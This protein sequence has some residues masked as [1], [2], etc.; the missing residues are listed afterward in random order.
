MEN[1]ASDSLN[2]YFNI[3]MHSIITRGEC[4]NVSMREIISNN[5]KKCGISFVPSL[6]V[7]VGVIRARSQ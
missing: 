4:R 7:K 3:H 6:P 5:C 2:S 1:Y